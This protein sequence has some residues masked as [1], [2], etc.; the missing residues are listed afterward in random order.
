MF[1]PETVHYSFIG[2]G[3]ILGKFKI[4]KKITHYL[5]HYENKMLELENNPRPSGC[6]KLQGRNGYRIRSGDYRIIYE[7]E[8][9]II[10]VTVIDVGHRKDIYQ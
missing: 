5:F 8:D 10:T 1:D 4:T 2:K 3:K 6:K 9:K 7:V